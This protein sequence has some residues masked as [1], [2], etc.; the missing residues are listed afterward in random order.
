VFTRAADQPGEPLAWEYSA[1]AA[2]L[3]EA[4]GHLQKTS[5]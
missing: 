2:Q 1:A 5:T 3:S 4:A